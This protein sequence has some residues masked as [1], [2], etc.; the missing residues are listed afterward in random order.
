M[1]YAR[2]KMS[3]GDISLRLSVQYEGEQSDCHP[4]GSRSYGRRVPKV[5]FVVVWPVVWFWAKS[6]D[7]PISNLLLATTIDQRTCEEHE[8]Y[9]G[10]KDSS[11]TRRP[12]FYNRK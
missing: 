1:E 5:S 10:Y 6:H 9:K 7:Y 4:P 11:Q 3:P 12:P 2:R 8:T